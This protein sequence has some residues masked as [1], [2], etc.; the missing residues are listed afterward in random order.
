MAGTAFLPWEEWLAR[1]LHALAVALRRWLYRTRRKK[2]LTR[3]KGGGQT[4]G[5]V[6]DV[7]WDS[8]NPREEVVYSYSTERGYYS[9]SYWHWFD[10][11]DKR[12]V[13]VGNRITLRFDPED[14]ESSVFLGFVE[15]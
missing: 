15:G 11:S 8:S 5:T 1:L 2:D 9:G 7:K 14:H 13:R 10:S 6:Q 3:S 12:Q 4:R